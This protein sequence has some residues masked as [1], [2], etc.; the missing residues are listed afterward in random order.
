MKRTG[1]YFLVIVVFLTTSCYTNQKFHVYG[2]PGTIITSMDENTTLAVIDQSGVAEIKVK[3]N[4]G[5]N[6][7]LLAKSPDSDNFIP[8]ALDYQDKNRSKTFGILYGCFLVP[9]LLFVGIA[10]PM[11]VFGSLMGTQ[12]DYDYLDYQHTNNDIIR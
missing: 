10:G 12:F 3:R 1:I 7:F 5:Y 4:D 6:A 2:V 8:F 9:P 11:W